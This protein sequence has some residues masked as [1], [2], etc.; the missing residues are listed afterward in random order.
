MKKLIV[1]LTV[2][3]SVH[4]AYSCGLEPDTTK[5]IIVDTKTKN[6]IYFGLLGNTPIFSINY[7]RIISKHISLKLGIGSLIT[8]SLI[9]YPI[10]LTLNYFTNLLNSGAEYSLG[11]SR[12][13]GVDGNQSFEIIS[14]GINYRYQSKNGGLFFKTGV[15]LMQVIRTEF[16]NIIP[17]P[18]LSI[19]IT[20]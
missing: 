17:I 3:F 12:V 14:F 15:D 5:N 10:N 9:G 2:V 11:I 13:L 8:I 19:G 6:T 16:Y 20:F 18:G 1:I 4:I 7:D